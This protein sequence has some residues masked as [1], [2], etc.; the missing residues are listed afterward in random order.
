MTNQSMRNRYY[1]FKFVF[2]CGLNQRGK[3]AASKVFEGTRMQ[4]WNNHSCLYSF[5][6]S[7]GQYRNPH[8]LFTAKFLK[9]SFKG[10][11]QSLCPIGEKGLK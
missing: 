7:E 3:E 2:Q 9:E 5:V 1:T 10:C 4:S 11:V 8:I 6:G